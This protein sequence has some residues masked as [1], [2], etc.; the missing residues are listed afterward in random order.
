MYQKKRKIADKDFARSLKK[1][2]EIQL[3]SKWKQRS[4]LEDCFVSYY[5]FKCMPLSYLIM[6][7]QCYKGDKQARRIQVTLRHLLDFTGACEKYLH[8]PQTCTFEHC[9]SKR[10]WMSWRDFKEA[11]WEWSAGLVSYWP[12][13]CEWTTNQTNCWIIEWIADCFESEGTL[14]VI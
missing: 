10:I 4:N 12:N 1:D 6:H 2:L 7:W 3:S 9:F 14:K 11:Q 13:I 8:F 5:A